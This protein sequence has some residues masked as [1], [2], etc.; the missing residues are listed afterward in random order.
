MSVQDDSP[1]HRNSTDVKENKAR[2]HS[3][4]IGLLQY[5]VPFVGHLLLTHQDLLI[6]IYVYRR[7]ILPGE[8]FSDAVHIIENY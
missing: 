8:I 6:S 3:N 7:E 4:V 5:R 2:K 1:C